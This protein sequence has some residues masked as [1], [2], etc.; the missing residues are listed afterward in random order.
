M[1]TEPSPWLGSPNKSK[2]TPYTKNNQIFGFPC[3]DEELQRMSCCSTTRKV[4]RRSVLP[5]GMDMDRQLV[6]RYLSKTTAGIIKV[7]LVWLQENKVIMQARC[8]NNTDE[9]NSNS[10]FIDI[11]RL[12][13]GV[14]NLYMLKSCDKLPQ[15]WL[16][17]WIQGKHGNLCTVW[18]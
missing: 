3:A 2:V 15:W 9:R 18:M 16:E 10:V 8:F 1:N 7:C 13:L 4:G 11:R 12:P 6:S 17:I 14:W 5:G